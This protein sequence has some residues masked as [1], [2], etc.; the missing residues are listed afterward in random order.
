MNSILNKNLFLIKE[1]IGMFK[2]ANNFDVLNNR[3]YKE[4][5]YS[6]YKY[7]LNK[8]ILNDG[9]IKYYNN[10]I[11]PLDVHSYSQAIILIKKL[12]PKNFSLSDKIV[13][14]LIENMYLIKNK[15]FRYQKGKYLSN[16]INYFR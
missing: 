13:N 12:D 3:N 1:H 10:A 9:R 6:G 15:R 11:Y 14:S 16:N 2:A 8:F 5:I 7:Y 4:A